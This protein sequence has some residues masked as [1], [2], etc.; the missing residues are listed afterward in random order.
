MVNKNYYGGVAFRRRLPCEK[1]KREVG[2]RTAMSGQR[3]L[4][5]IGD[6]YWY[7]LS[8]HGTG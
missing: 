6:G 5:T 4:E 8:T 1:V 7:Y 2:P 3:L